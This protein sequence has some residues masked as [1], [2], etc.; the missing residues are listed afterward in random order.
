MNRHMKLQ[1]S[2]LTKRKYREEKLHH[3]EL[4]FSI[5]EILIGLVL[6]LFL[7]TGIIQ[8]F[9]ANKQTY[10][11]QEEASR[12]QE[13]GRFALEVLTNSIRMAGFTGCNVKSCP[14]TCPLTYPPITPACT[15]PA[16]PPLPCPTNLC[17]NP[18]PPNIVL[19]NPATWWE[20]LRN[21]PLRG[22]DGSD[23]P[24]P[25]NPFP[26]RIDGTDAIIALGGNG[27]LHFVTLPDPV[28]PLLMLNTLNT[29]QE[30]SLKK[31][32]IVIMCNTNYTSLFQITN[33]LN[34][35]PP[36]IE[37]AS[38]VLIPGNSSADFNGTI[39]N[40]K[41][42]NGTTIN[43]YA[44]TAFYIR[45]SVSDTTRSLYQSNL[46]T[47]EDG[48]SS[49]ME[50]EELIEGVWDMQIVY[51]VDMD[52][53]SNSIIDKYV[54]ASEV[55]NRNQWSQVL[56]V[57][58]NLLLVSLEDN[59][60]NQPQAY[61]FPDDIGDGAISGRPVLATDRRLYQVFSTTIGIRNRLK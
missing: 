17:T 12:M 24:M 6:G 36:T 4:G 44:P 42:N 8:L 38:G 41:A 56:S 33:I 43:K 10:R 28:S 37:Y 30:K 50:S 15:P 57:R 11:F 54:D 29:L 40:Y 34:V 31:G 53:P 52:N 26:N 20:D 9:I 14:A 25:P 48:S 22:Y 27:A 39:A 49:Y 3:Q 55:T 16:C 18:F 23:T 35:A 2:S 1:I 59:I 13:N 5:V 61:M 32:N 47:A 21:N 58:I 19:N 45:T 46:V 51:G 7:G 60:V